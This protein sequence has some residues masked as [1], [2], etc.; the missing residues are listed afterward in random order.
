[1]KNEAVVIIVGL[2]VEM[3]N[4]LVL[5]AG[6]LRSITTSWGVTADTLQVIS[7][8]LSLADEHGRLY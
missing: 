7:R 8:F 2:R 3:L 4:S 6:L 5:L 1:M